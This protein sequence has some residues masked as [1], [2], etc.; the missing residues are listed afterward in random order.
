MTQPFLGLVSMFAGNFAPRG[1]A[2]ANGQLLQLSQNQALFALYGTT[3]GGNGVQTFGLPDLRGRVPVGMGQG[4]GLSPYQIGQVG[5]TES[6]TVLTNQLPIHTHTAMASSAA[7]AQ[8]TPG[9]NV[10]SQM[11]ATLLAL[12]IPTGKETG[13]T[14]VL[15]QASIGAVGGS[16]PH[17]NRMPILAVTFIVALTG[18]FPSRN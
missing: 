4:S 16:Q 3:Y 5:G 10:L 1:Y 8:S 14:Q 6:V 18:I 15:N 9:G 17:E 12:Y 13:P 2:Q 7:A 11:D